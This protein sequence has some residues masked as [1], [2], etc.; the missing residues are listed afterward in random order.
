[1]K[2][3]VKIIVGLFLPI[4]FW[5]CATIPGESVKLSEN[6]GGMI[7]SSRASHINLVNRYFDDRIETIKDFALNE[8]K[9]AFMKNVQKRLKEQGEEL[10]IERYDQATN[11]VLKK[12]N[13]WVKEAEDQHT[14]V[15]LEVSEHYDRMVRAN[16]S[17]T[18]LLRSASQI[19]EV[20]KKLMGDLEQKSDKVVNFEKLDSQMQAILGKIQQAKDAFEIMEGKNAK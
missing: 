11:R 1:M 13:E 7:S 20:R 2:K 5:G 15:L 10:T 17:V 9:P 14:V 6:L 19:E 18:S 16:E 8:Y 3:G 4:S 12:M